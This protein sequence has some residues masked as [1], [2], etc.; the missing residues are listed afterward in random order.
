MARLGSTMLDVP[1]RSHRR[2]GKALARPGRGGL[3]SL[4]DYAGAVHVHS[5]YSDG[6]GT[7]PEIL[8]AARGAELD[9]VLL[10]DHAEMSLCGRGWEAWHDGVLLALGCELSPDGEPHSLALELADASGMSALA[11]AERL[12]EVNARGGLSFIAHPRG[13]RMVGMDIPPWREWS[14][15]FITGLEVWSFT[16]DWLGTFRWRRAISCYRRPHARVTGPHP[17][18]LATWDRLASRRP[19]SG[20]AGVDAH[21]RPTAFGRFKIFPYDMLFR[22][23]LTHVLVEELGHDASADASAVKEALAAGRCYMGYHVVG[24]PTG[25]RFIAASDSGAAQM[26]ETAALA[27]RPVLRVALPASAEIRFIANGRVVSG[28]H[29]SRAEFAPT[30]SGPHRVEVRHAGRPWIFSNHIHI[31]S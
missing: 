30:E 4:H 8:D 27:K 6:D 17:D 23:T 24:D 12:A 11:P 13:H 16:Y 18:V 7:I 31:A 19:V 25:F 26:G 2:A 14:S 28:R 15:P 10:T 21:A 3:S 1:N 29:S 20:I 22:T 5:T 9:F